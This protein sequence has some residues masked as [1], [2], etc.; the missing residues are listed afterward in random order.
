[1]EAC[2][3]AWVLSQ[4]GGAEGLGFGFRLWSSG[5]GG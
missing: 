2:K 1:M 4:Q 3:E 5:F